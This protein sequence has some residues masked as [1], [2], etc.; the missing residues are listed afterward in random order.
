MI[1]IEDLYKLALLLSAAFGLFVSVRAHLR[2]RWSV[3]RE[4]YKFTK[5]VCEDLS[6]ATQMHPFQKAKAY[7]ALSG[8]RT[9]GIDEG[10][11]LFSLHDPDWSVRYFVQ[12]RKYLE[13]S[14]NEESPQIRLKSK[15]RSSFS[16]R[17]RVAMYFSGYVFF[18]IL[19]GIPLFVGANAFN[20]IPA[21]LFSF[22]VCLSVFG[23]MAALSLKAA[24][25]LAMATELV[26]KQQRR[27]DSQ[28]D[29][30]ESFD[31]HD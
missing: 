23:T 3:M 11:Y 1:S 24:F 2:G 20:G 9:M 17:W 27:N 13:Y 16:R 30:T 14:P 31:N 6:A 28:S 12:A 29:V 5:D 18:V 10:D 21:W 8:D 25:R 15:Y 19:A 4:D 22:T 26:R 7:Q